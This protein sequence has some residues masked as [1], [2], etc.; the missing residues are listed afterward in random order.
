MDIWERLYQAA[1]GEYHP[2]EV[3]PFVM[4]TMSC[5]RWRARMEATIRGL[6]SR[7]AAA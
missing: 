5:A 2:E 6:A 4:R 7:P 3:S 1:Q